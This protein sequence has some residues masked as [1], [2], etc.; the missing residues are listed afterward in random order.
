MRS[1]VEDIQNIPEPCEAV[2]QS[3]RAAER[4]EA[5]ATE[6]FC[7]EEKHATGGTKALAHGRGT[8]VMRGGRSDGGS[9]RN[10]GAGCAGRATGRTG[11][12]RSGAEW[13]G[14]AAAPHAE[15]GRWSAS[16]QGGAAECSGAERK[17][18]RAG[19]VKFEPE[20]VPP[21]P[22]ETGRPEAETMRP[23]GERTHTE[24]RTGGQSAEAEPARSGRKA[25][26]AG[27]GRRD[28]GGS[29]GRA[30]PEQVARKEAVMRAEINLPGT[31]A[32]GR[33]RSPRSAGRGRERTGR[34]IGARR[35]SS[36]SGNLPRERTPEAGSGA[37]ATRGKRATVQSLRRTPAAGGSER[38][39]C[40]ESELQRACAC[41][42]R[43]GGVSTKG[44]LPEP[45][46]A[47]PRSGTEQPE[48]GAG[49]ASNR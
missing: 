46:E 33:P 3:D 26:P 17:P 23:N 43:R 4:R 16:A 28:S 10:A 22:A 13:S 42:G 21:E 5:F 18:G 25:G 45:A 47:V 20:V 49:A 9:T 2:V 32:A 35:E 15:T 14:D 39:G 11:L 24:K 8:K 37:S 19:G 1:T 12:S 34:L 31:D 48:A 41:A 44:V 30:E 40:P 38:A 7:P 36:R 6:A 29:G 27:N